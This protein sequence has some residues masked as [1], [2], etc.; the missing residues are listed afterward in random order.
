MFIK[1]VKSKHC[2]VQ[3]V[4]GKSHS[5]LSPAPL[6]SRLRRASKQEAADSQLSADNEAVIHELQ[7]LV[8]A[9]KERLLLTTIPIP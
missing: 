8:T 6:F 5:L 2:C 3:N 1:P 4:L 7:I 9:P